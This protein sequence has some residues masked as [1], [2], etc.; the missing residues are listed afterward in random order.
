MHSIGNTD[1]YLFEASYQE[2]IDSKI[3]NEEILAAH[4]KSYI[5]VNEA[6]Y[7]QTRVVLEAKLGDSI[8]SKW[9]KFTDFIKNMFAKFMEKITHLLYD[10]KDY[11]EKY[12]DI[13][14]KKP[15]KESLEFSYDGDYKTAINRCIN[16]EVPLFNY[17]THAKELKAEGYG[18][19]AKKIMQGKSGFSY[20][21]S[22]NLAESFKSYFLA[23]DEGDKSGNFSELN[24]PEMYK[25]CYNAKDIENITRKDQNYLDNSTKAIMNFIETELAKPKQEA[26]VMETQLNF[27]KQP[28][29]QGQQGGT[30]G[31]QSGIQKQQGGSDQP[32]ATVTTSTSD[33]SKNNNNGN[34]GEEKAKS[35]L[36]ITKNTN[37]IS[38]MGSHENDRADVTDEDKQAAANGVD[39]E[40]NVEKVQEMLDKWTTV[41]RSLIAA[42]LTAVQQ[43]AKDYMIIIRE[44][45]QS[46]VGTADAKDDTIKSS[47]TAETDYTKNRVQ[48]QRKKESE[49]NN[50]NT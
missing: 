19:I 38:Q 47:K 15:P 43:I 16:T 14:L 18:E 45:V 31:Q 26:Y 5:P 32:K 1:N 35:N 8:K 34:D 28:N 36:T 46:Y 48:K 40:E 44:H 12:K 17:A 4:L 11:L 20:D 49:T 50:N 39:A 27:K 21:E 23:L 24:F 10:Q 42:K 22:K 37:A 13:I 30:S 25:F 29:V 9:T 33:Q 6:T 2:Y 7:R 41:C 3:R